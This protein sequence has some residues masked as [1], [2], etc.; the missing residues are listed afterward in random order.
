MASQVLIN[1]RYELKD[2]LGQGGMGIVYRAYDISTKRDVALKTMHDAADP[3]SVELFSKEWSVLAKLCHPNIVDILDCGEFEGKGRLRP[4]FVMPLLPGRT[5][6]QLIHSSS[7]RLTISRVVEIFRQICRGLQAAHERGLVH[8]DLKPS[9]IFVMEDDTAKIIDFGVVHLTGSQ[10]ITGLKGT[11][12]YMAPEQLELKPATPQSDIF[13]LGVAA[14]EAFTGRKPFARKSEPDTA[15]AVRLHIPP[16]ASEINPTVGDQL[17]RVLHKAMAKQPWNRFSSAREFGDTLEKALR[18]ELAFDNSK[19][20][21]RV[22][23]ATKAFDGGDLQFASEI[24]NELESEGNIDSDMSLLRGQ[25]EQAGRQRTIRQLLESARSRF[26]QEEHPLAL[27]KVQEVLRIDPG[28]SE[29]LGMR[30]EIEAQRS[31][32]QIERWVRLARE[33]LD[34]GA[35]AEAR[36]GLE[37]ALKANFNDSRVLQL[38]SEVSRQEQ[39]NSKARQ[40]KEQ[41]YEAA[42]LAIQ[43]GEIS[44]ALSKLERI[45]ELNQRVPD[46][47]SPERD[48][49]YQKL[50]NQVRSENDANRSAYEE[51]RRSLTEKDFA[52]AIAICEE[53][54]KKY[55]GQA[56]FQ[57]LKLEVGERERQEVYSYISEIE[58]RLDA[59]PDL[60]RKLS[61]AKEAADRYPQEAQ[62][63][64]SL[65]L[66]RDRRDLIAGIVAKGRQYEERGQLAEALGQWE[67][68]RGIYPQ[69]PGLTF[70]IEQ[71]KRRRDQQ[72]RDEAKS[73]WV[74]QADSALSAGDYHRAK[75]L[76]NNGLLEFPQDP[77]LSSL[78]RLAAQSLDRKQNA[79]QLLAKGQ[80]LCASNHFDE[81]LA[82]LR[83]AAALD[84][85]DDSVRCALVEALTRRADEL[86]NQDWTA[87][88]PLIQS[89]LD[90]DPN[91]AAAK[92][93]RAQIQ[94]Q[95]RRQTVDFCLADARELRGAG[96]YDGAYA[97]IK[98]GLQSYPYDQRLTQFLTTLERERPANPLP[99]REELIPA[100]VVSAKPDPFQQTSALDS[101]F[102]GSIALADSVSDARSVKPVARHEPS[103]DQL[104]SSSGVHQ[105]GNSSP[106]VDMPP[107][108]GAPQVPQD[109]VPGLLPP[110]RPS[111]SSLL[112]WGGLSAVVVILLAAW[113]T[114][115]L[116]KPVPSKTRPI[117]TPITVAATVTPATAKLYVDGSEVSS[118]QLQLSKGSHTVQASAPGYKTATKNLLAIP[119]M[120]PI[121]LTLEPEPQHVQIISSFP[122][123]KVL[124]DGDPVGELSA[125]QFSKDDVSF[126][127]HTLQVV[128][129]GRELI[130]VHLGGSPAHA[131][132]VL[133]PVRDN[134]VV[135][136]SFGSAG[137]IFTG[138]K[139]QLQKNGV[140][141]VIPAEG[142]DISNTN[143]PEIS[144]SDGKVQKSFAL[145]SANYPILAVYANLDSNE[146]QPLVGITTNVDEPEVSIN[147]KAVAWRTYKGKI[148]GRLDPG[149]YLVKLSKPGFE[150]SNQD[151]VLVKGDRKQ[152]RL[153]L[154][155]LPT[156]ASLAV[157]GGIPGTTVSIADSPK[158]QIGSDGRLVLDHLS[159]GT[160]E[161]V[162]QKE[163]YESKRVMKTFVV[164]QAVR[165]TAA[166]SRLTPFG[167]LNFRVLT[168]GAEVTYRRKDEAQSHVAKNNETVSLAEG[169]YLVRASA[170][171]YESKEVSYTVTP[172][173]APTVSWALQK[174]ETKPVVQAENAFSAVEDPSQWQNLNGWI[175][176]QGQSYGW[177]KR[178][179]G[180]FSIDIRKR[181]GN[182]FGGGGGI[183]FVVGYFEKGKNRVSYHI[184]KLGYV[185]RKLTINGQTKED[186]KMVRIAGDDYFR[187][188]ITIEPTR[189]T[190]HDGRGAL[191]DDCAVSGFDLTVGKFGFKSGTLLNATR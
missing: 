82:V 79:K 5:L 134:V 159:P 44:T 106:L 113:A 13:S 24:L 90:L 107:G 118:S 150:D 64:Q 136:S 100:Q 147:G 123:G 50:Y 121:S 148:W 145:E 76:A 36:Q 149:T 99:R 84:T 174:T 41:L 75:E 35:F 158:G 156:F 21:S 45:L 59:E 40:Q 73:H 135:L 11:V 2:S 129:K 57:A 61:I 186:S 3:L 139:L 33:H 48:A 30:H 111:Q 104:L 162:L 170:E 37:E 52:K 109:V 132:T 47:T 96:D 184:D 68:L 86:M 127:E 141:Q 122:A 19:I 166:E 81:G 181:A 164:S 51:A 116:H 154:K 55:P 14:Y 31:Q 58:R 152:L 22:E 179:Q 114:T 4:Y 171:G 17:S 49:T 53:N 178:A 12:Q 38:L 77:E 95:L 65:R 161:I 188:Q 173:S 74:D 66:L 70:E 185:S 67:I 28:N 60:D 115:S 128:D 138:P 88:E 97:K 191:V 10:S 142:L 131:P 108:E 137:R 91:N 85:R 63:V 1:R 187:L 110:N 119:G 34:R 133:S 140:N 69:Y 160:H 7:E 98:T 29:A 190:I 180:H 32:Q 72:N 183:D 25:I 92:S 125:G 153:E 15:E 43:S 62:F 46:R 165:L 120:A 175:V 93:I 176:Y 105:N 18:G 20:R 9:N 56:L 182:V 6:E 94:D 124:L 16:A 117:A 39:E 167:M 23:R 87:A 177:M 101:I 189:V 157:E 130:N 27:Q 8:R 80:Q 112:K 89:A 26:E 155:A 168:A 144:V 103:L 151:L 146:A 143:G 163:N 172:G 169:T 126:A 102:G 71:I 78:D 54:L 42:K 83:Q